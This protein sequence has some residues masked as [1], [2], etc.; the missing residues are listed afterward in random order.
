M[1]IVAIVVLTVGFIALNNIGG[2]Q[3][4]SF[5]AA[6]G[7]IVRYVI[8]GFLGLLVI[9]FLLNRLFQDRA[10][11]RAAR[12]AQDGKYE[13]AIASIS[14]VISAKGPTVERLNALG[15]LMMDQNRPTESLEQFDCCESLFGMNA[16]SS[17]NRAVVLHR[18]GR[19]EEAVQAFAKVTEQYPKEFMSHCN[20]AS[21][22]ADMGRTT[23]AYEQLT[24]A[25]TIAAQYEPRN[26]P[27][28]WKQ[29]M[30]ECRSKLPLNQGFEV[31]PKKPA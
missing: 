15:L 9:L 4:R 28:D 25:E 10:V 16:G 23:E 29:A 3:G 11:V 13:E 18:M 14:G 6:T 17:N 8:F 30:E 7:S 5:M 12:L 26:V 24:R 19:L 22:L 20:Y 21:L 1:L 31:V 27:A 2:D